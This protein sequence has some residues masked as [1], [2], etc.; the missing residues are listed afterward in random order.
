MSL[1]TEDLLLN[2]RDASFHFPE[3]SS[4][5]TIDEIIVIY[6]C[7]NY[8]DFALSLNAVNIG[9]LVIPNVFANIGIDDGVF[10]LLLF[11]D[12]KDVASGNYKYSI[13][14]LQYASFQFQ[15]KYGFNSFR[16]Q[17]DNGNEN[18]YYFDNNGVGPL[19]GDF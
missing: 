1:L 11:F 18:E 4:F 6:N 16:C 3:D 7:N 12:L 9:E 13:D 14:I 8:V 2:C 10:E 17:I 19:Y 5:K 15:N